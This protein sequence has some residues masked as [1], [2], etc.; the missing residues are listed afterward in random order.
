MRERRARRCAPAACPAPWRRWRRVAAVHSSTSKRFAG[1]EHAARRL[2]HAVI[3]AADALQQPRCA[4]GRADIDHEIDVAP[5]DAEVERRGADHG[6]QSADRHRLLDLAALRH[7]ERT[8]MQRDRKIVVVDAP[9]VPERSISAWLRVLTNTSVVLWLLDQPV[10]FRDRVSR[11]VSG[12][13]QALSGIEHGDVR[14]RTDRRRSRDRRAWL[15]PCVC[16]IR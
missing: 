1:I 14:W 9:Q 13:R 11:A 16:G 12:P 10:D 4:L 6:A 2:V 15:R 7:V 3:G 8:V 5:V